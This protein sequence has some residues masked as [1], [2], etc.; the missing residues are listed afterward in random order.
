MSFKP[1]KIADPAEPRRPSSAEI[2]ATI[3]PLAGNLIATTPQ[4]AP[5]PTATAIAAPAKAEPSLMMSFKASKSFARTLAKAAEPEGGLRKL[6]ARVF[7]E[8]GY[9]VPHADLVGTRK[10]RTYD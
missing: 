1:K 5:T 10:R 3:G 9:E 4:P 6:I 8:A 7:H 2:A